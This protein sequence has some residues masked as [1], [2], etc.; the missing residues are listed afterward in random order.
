MKITFLGHAAFFIET[1]QTSLLIDPFLTGNP[2]ATASATDFSP[3]YILLT[4]GHG[5]HVGDTVPI[6]QR[7]GSTV[8]TT[9]ELGNWLAKK[10]VKTSAQNHGGWHKYPFGVVKF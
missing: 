10:G 9:Y 6:A 8:I 7:A 3:E 4:H 1:A 2:K 5:D